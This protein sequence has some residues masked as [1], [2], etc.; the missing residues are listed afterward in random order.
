[1]LLMCWFQWSLLLMVIA[2]YSVLS[3]VTY[4]ISGLQWV[5]LSFVINIACWARKC[6]NA[7][8]L[9][10]H[11][12]Y[13]SYTYCIHNVHISFHNI[14]GMTYYVNIS[15]IDTPI[16]V[17]K[18]LGFHVWSCMTPFIILFGRHGNGEYRITGAYPNINNLPDTVLSRAFLFA[19]DTKIYRHMQN[20]ENHN[21]FQDDIFKP[22]EW[23]NK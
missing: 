8:N 15:V 16:Q 5:K 2:E 22:Q 13:I 19:A 9:L 3:W 21:V 7:Y 17:R 4:I 10:Q 18:L 1:M 14:F 20:I 11:I 6:A 12:L 23:V